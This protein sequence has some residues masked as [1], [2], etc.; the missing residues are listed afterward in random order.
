MLKQE[1]SIEVNNLTKYYGPVMAI[2][3]VSFNVRKGEIVGFL[4]P[5][6][7][8]KSTTMRILSGLITAKSG[9]AKICGIPIASSPDE[10]KKHIGYMAENNPLPEDMRVVEYI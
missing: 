1:H 9:S 2:H 5:N 7:A 3:K 4:G 6:G 10:I 8:G